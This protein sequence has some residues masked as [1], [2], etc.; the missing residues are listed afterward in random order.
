MFFSKNNAQQAAIKENEKDQE[1]YS[2]IIN[3]TISQS[4]V[5]VSQIKD[6]E[7]KMTSAI[8]ITEEEKIL[9]NRI[10]LDSSQALDSIS[11][12]KQYTEGSSAISETSLSEIMSTRANINESLDAIEMLIDTSS[13]I[14]DDLLSL[15]STLKRISKVAAGIHII[16]KQTN[17]LAL[18]ATIEAARAGES[19]LGF[20]NVAEEVKNLSSET[21][22]AT[23]E[24]DSILKVLNDQ[25]HSLIEEST[26]GAGK[27]REIKTC[28]KAIKDIYDTLSKTTSTV[29][30]AS[31]SIC[32]NT[33]SVAEQCNMTIDKLGAIQG[34]SEKSFESLLIAKENSATLVSESENLLELSKNAKE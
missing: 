28:R 31:G 32:K 20:A 12:I 7:S 18:N 10:T 23:R 8:K 33:D 26:E 9:L 19:G 22:K 4:D 29:S 30:N 6:V 34:E 3:N 15:A 25:I 27:K 21:S 24:I 14:K 2:R 16:A 1:L 5:I 17:L 13:E 11:E